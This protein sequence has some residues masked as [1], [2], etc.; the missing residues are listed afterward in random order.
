MACFQLPC[1]RRGTGSFGHAF[2]NVEITLSYHGWR[3][4]APFKDLFL[5]LKLLRPSFSSYCQ[6][7][8]IAIYENNTH[9]GTRV[10]RARR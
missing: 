6:K 2:I 8:L 4:A 1:H 10:L 9:L 3:E 5:P 7:V